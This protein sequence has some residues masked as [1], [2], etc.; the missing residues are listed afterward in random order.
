MKIAVIVPTYRRPRDLARCL[1]ALAA[2]ERQAAQV[3]VVARDDDADTHA[4][5]RESPAL[6]L[7][8]ATVVEPGQV[9]ALNAGLA[10]ADADI[11]AFTDDDAAPRPDWLQRIAAH[12]AHDRSLGGLGGRDWIYQHGALEH[13]THPVVGR[14]GWF[15]RCRGNHHLGAGAPR[16]V[17]V[18]KGVNMAY[19][20]RALD[21]IRFDA[22]LRGSG[23][24]VANDLGVS[25]AVRRA[26]WKLLYDPAVAVDHFPAERHDEDRRDAFS[27]QA[28]ANAAF[29]ETLLLAEHF[30]TLRRLAFIGWALAIGH[31]A[32]P[33]ALQW[34]RLLAL[35]PRT[36]TARFL[37]A[38]RGRWAALGVSR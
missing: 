35:Q 9:A 6:P 13:G 24:Q 11:V 34:A 5:L 2:Q 31:R 38:L 37:A 7:R 16:N 26:G 29:N 15:G 18:L 23:A 17:D 3:V 19:R 4:A 25:L 8:I 10:A 22:R 21:G 36:A 1:V 20:A 33:G 14:V 12:F 27:A 28:I 30:G 32:A